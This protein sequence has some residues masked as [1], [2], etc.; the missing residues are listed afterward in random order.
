MACSCGGAYEWTPSLEAL[1]CVKCGRHS[2]YRKVSME[3]LL[4]ENKRLKAENERLKGS[5]THSS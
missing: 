1:V 3:E 2:Q 5:T 4:E